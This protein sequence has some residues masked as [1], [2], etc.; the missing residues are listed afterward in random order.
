VLERRVDDVVDRDAIRE[1]VAEYCRL[2]VRR[3]AE[4][5]VGLFTDDASLVTHFPEGSGQDDIETHG[6]A[7]LRKAYDDVGPIGPKPCI[8]NHIIE[9]DGDQARGFCSVEIRLVQEGVAYTGSGHYED[10]YRR[11]GSDWRFRR[12]EIFVYHWVPHTEG[13]A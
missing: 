4:G 11:V 13:W 1:L 9:L 10:E 12:R 7:D 6:A 8:H 3:D 2:V 5:L